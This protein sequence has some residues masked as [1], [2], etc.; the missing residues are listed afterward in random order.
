MNFDDLQK[1]VEQ[2]L[3]ITEENL[4]SKSMEIPSIYNKYLKFYQT[5]YKKYKE[6]QTK[7]DEKYSELFEYYLTSYSVKLKSNEVDNF[8]KGDPEYTK[9]EKSLGIVKSRVDY[10]EGVLKQIGQMSFNIG[11]AISYIKF[12][13]GIV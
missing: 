2:D 9:I 3:Q 7:R 1:E 4:H 5:Y 12:K 13:E 10:L 11:N 6:L 8:V